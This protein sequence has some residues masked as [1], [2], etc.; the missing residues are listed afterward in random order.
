MALVHFRKGPER[1]TLLRSPSTLV[2]N[3]CIG[4]MILSS[5]SDHICMVGEGMKGIS[6]LGMNTVTLPSRVFS[7][8][9]GHHNPR[10]RIPGL[11]ECLSP[12]TRFRD[13]TSYIC[14][15]NSEDF[16]SDFN[17]RDSH[18]VRRFSW[19]EPVRNPSAHSPTTN[20]ISKQFI[21]FTRFRQI[22][23][24]VLPCTLPIV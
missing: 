4:A 13:S 11:A 21:H 3:D 18:T 14:T 6:G 10:D 24:P 5:R 8:Q 1:H 23:T 15:L 16:V 22:A 7:T 20:K 9:K 19:R 17:E 2:D 12:K